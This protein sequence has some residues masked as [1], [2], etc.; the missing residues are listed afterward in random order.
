VGEGTL[1]GP[2]HLRGPVGEERVEEP[3][4]GLGAV[5]VL[6]VSG[7]A[8]GE[9]NRA[10]DE[11]PLVRPPRPED[12][13]GVREVPNEEVTCGVGRGLAGVPVLVCGEL[14]QALEGARGIGAAAEERRGEPPRLGRAGE[15]PPHLSQDVVLGK[16]DKNAIPGRPAPPPRFQNP[17]ARHGGELSERIRIS[18]NRSRPGYNGALKEG[19]V[20]TLLIVG[21][22]IGT[23][24]AGQAAEG[25]PL[26]VGMQFTVPAVFGV[27]ARYWATDVSGLEGSVFLFSTDGDLWGMAGGR[28]LL[29]LAQ[30]ELAGFYLAFGGS[31]YFPERQPAVI[32]CGGID[33]VLPF[34]RSLTAN[35]E[36]GFVWHRQA[37]FGMAFGSGIHFYFGR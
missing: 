24:V 14:A 20:R 8:G 6:S 35:V 13:V 19:S 15:K 9:G 30:A 32:L 16:F 1:D 21:V 11:G 33:L 23:I 34:A 29:R 7:H 2:P 22:L 4:Q 18:S 37:G 5:Q 12:R 28:G 25:V 31:F 3:E 17:L 36:F 10:A 27:S 26:G